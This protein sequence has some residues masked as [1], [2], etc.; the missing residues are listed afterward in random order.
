M[1]PVPFVLKS[2]L[3]IVVTNFDCI[4]FSLNIIKSYLVINENSYKSD[5]LFIGWGA[6]A[7][8]DQVTTEKV[9]PH[10]G[11]RL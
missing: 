1:N 3:C 8:V 4:T 2:D 11:Y 7:S 5:T 6:S 10:D 9:N